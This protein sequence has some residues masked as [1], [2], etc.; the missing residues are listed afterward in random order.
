MT[1]TNDF[2]V[3]AILL[4]WQLRTEAQRSRGTCPGDPAGQWG[5]QPH[6]GSHCSTSPTPTWTA[7]HRSWGAGDRVQR[8]WPSFAA[9]PLNDPPFNSLP[10]VG[11][12]K[13][14]R[15]TW[16]FPDS[17]VSK[18]SACSEGDPCSIPGSGRSAREGIGYP[19]R[20]SWASLVAQLVKNPPVM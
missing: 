19:L 3:D 18:E 9:Y 13:R 7:P 2:K 16:V 11:M 10:L 6:T 1:C 20:D 15:E 5:S 17:S 8:Q 14:L 12:T 4:L